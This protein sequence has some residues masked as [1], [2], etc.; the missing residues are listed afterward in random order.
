MRLPVRLSVEIWE[1]LIQG[2]AADAA[3][4]TGEPL[5]SVE[6][7]GEPWARDLWVV[8][9]AGQKAGIFTPP[10]TVPAAPVVTNAEDA[11]L[12]ARRDAAEKRSRNAWKGGAS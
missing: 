8:V 4:R 9:R 2:L 6:P 12:A 3:A 11:A 5:P 1:A 7:G 10:G